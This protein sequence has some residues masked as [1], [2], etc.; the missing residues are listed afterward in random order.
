MG[1]P[2]PIYVNINADADSITKVE[3]LCMNCHENGETIIMMTK[4]PFF[5]EM[6]VMSFHCQHCGFRNN[7]VQ[8]GGK[9]ELNGVRVIAIVDGSR[10][11]NRQIVKSEHCTVK[12]PEL[13]FEIPPLT[14]K[15]TLSTIEGLVMKASADLK[16]TA[17]MN[18]DQNP[19]WAAQVK[20]F[21]EDKLEKIV[22]QDKADTFGTDQNNDELKGRG[23]DLTNEVVEFNER[24]ISCNANVVCRM[25]LVQIPFFKEITLMAVNC[26]HCGYRSN[27]VKAG[28]GI[29]DKGK[30]HELKVR[31]IEDLARLGHWNGLLGGKFTTVEGLLTDLRTDLIDK[32]PFSSGDSSVH[33]GRNERYAAF[34]QRINDILELKTECTLILDDPAGNSYILSL[35]A[36]EPDPQLF[37]EEYERNWEQNEDLGINDMI[38]EN[39]ENDATAV[40]PPKKQKLENVVEEKETDEAMTS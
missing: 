13:D 3:S 32:N 18:K 25:K 26:E 31:T 37:E 22:E 10:D 34:R 14:Q 5:K 6:I 35:C 19:E 29:N 21:C 27:E 23:V 11:L 38:T 4:I 15:G 24:C 9:V 7:E 40:S 30:R 20:S 36:P 33:E 1:D 16:M 8:S 12:I 17:E 2:E 28:G 39:Y